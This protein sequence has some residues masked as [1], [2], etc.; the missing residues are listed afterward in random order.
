MLMNKKQNLGT[1]KNFTIIIAILIFFA[2]LL[3]LLPYFNQY[4]AC[5]NDEAILLHKA[6]RIL[7]GEVIYKNF[8]SH[9]PIMP[10]L[11]QNALF[12]ILGTNMF[13]ARLLMLIEGGIICLLIFLLSKHIFPLKIAWLPSFLFLT[14]GVPHWPIVSY[15]WISIIF[16]LISLNLILSW[17]SKKN[18]IYLYFSGISSG[19]ALLSF[20]T[21]GLILFFF[22]PCIFL[23]ERLKNKNFPVMDSLY[24]AFL[25]YMTVITPFLLY[26]YFTGAVEQFLMQNLFWALEEGISF[27]TSPFKLSYMQSWIKDFVLYY[28]EAQKEGNLTFSWL[29]NALS[30]LGIQILKYALFYPIIIA[31]LLFLWRDSSLSGDRKE[32]TYILFFALLLWI[33]MSSSRQTPLYLN[34]LTCLWYIS[35]VSL[36]FICIRNSLILRCTLVFLIAMFLIHNFFSWSDSKRF[37]YPIYAPRGKLYSDHPEFAK[38]INRIIWH[39]SSNTAENNYIF[40]YSFL[41]SFYFLSGRKNPTRYGVIVPIFSPRQ[42]IYEAKSD[43]EKKKVPF[44]YVLPLNNRKQEDYP[45]ID[46]DKYKEES[47]WMN[48]TLL[49][50]Y[51]LNKRIGIFFIFSRK[52]Y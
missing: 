12:K 2:G 43:I 14:T 7:H 33:I 26:L 20:P 13:S 6:E 23:W 27:N 24:P 41:P 18:K 48:N 11:L 47:I 46:E 40:T 42:I 22:I 30:F 29:L 49:E 37:I 3:N 25:G 10:Y 44:I 31:Q 38:D 8:F 15:H 50:G 9:F 51:K 36:L 45:L 1:G 4:N 28:K 35:L 32:K 17:S 16:M 19:L 39:I 34:Y 21:E 5:I 52:N